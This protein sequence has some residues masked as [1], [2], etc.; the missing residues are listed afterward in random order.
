MAK[1]QVIRI[2]QNARDIMFLEERRRSDL[3]AEAVD[4]E[5]ISSRAIG[6]TAT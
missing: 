2:K 6:Q 3:N 1:P 4:D 5:A